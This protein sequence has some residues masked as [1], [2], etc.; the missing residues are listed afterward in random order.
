MEP[1]PPGLCA[2]STA[3]DLVA[4]FDGQ[5]AFGEAHGED[6]SC[7]LK[8][9][10]AEGEGLMVRIAGTVPIFEAKAA[11]ADQGVPF[12][13]VEGLGVDAFRNSPGHG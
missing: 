10:D 6:T 5:L 2:T 11:Y 9:V 8:I 3:L 7:T 13:E 1:P 12:R 4:A